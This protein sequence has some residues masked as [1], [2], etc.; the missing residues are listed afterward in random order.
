MSNQP[1]M[2]FMSCMFNLKIANMYGNAFQMNQN[3]QTISNSTSISDASS[4][5]YNPMMQNLDPP[6]K[7]RLRVQLTLEER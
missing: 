4:M 6:K 3:F 5:F 7:E 1:G 2:N